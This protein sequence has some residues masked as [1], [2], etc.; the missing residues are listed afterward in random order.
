MFKKDKGKVLWQEQSRQNQ[1]EK[2]IGWGMARQIPP[3]TK[4][5]YPNI[6]SEWLTWLVGSSKSRMEGATKS[7]LESATLI[8][9][10]PL[11]SLHFLWIVLP[12]ET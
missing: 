9:H 5:K 3:S 4:Y 11:M 12:P 6:V 2:E 8:L 7:A 10:P 1:I